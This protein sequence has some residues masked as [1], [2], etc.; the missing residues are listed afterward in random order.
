MQLLLVTVRM[1]W[2][3][4]DLDSVTPRAHSM[5]VALCGIGSVV[6]LPGCASSHQSR[7]TADKLPQGDTLPNNPW[8]IFQC[9]FSIKG[10]TE[11]L[12]ERTATCPVGPELDL[13]TGRPSGE[14]VPSDAAAK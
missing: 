4:V 8:V 12:S 10:R 5:P 3:E 14:M 13:A 7:Q 11:G 1:D 2:S 9:L 6:F